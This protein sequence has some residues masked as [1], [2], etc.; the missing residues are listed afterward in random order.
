MWSTGSNIDDNGF[1]WGKWKVSKDTYILTNRWGNF[2]YLLL[3]SEKAMLIDTGYG[4]GNIRKIVESITSLPVTVV[5]THGH[6]D[7]VGGN[8]YWHECYCGRKAK[9]DVVSGAPTE[10]MEYFNANMP[11][12]FIWHEV[13][14]GDTFE[15]GNRS[16]EVFAVRAHAESGIALLDKTNRL[17][18][19]GDEIDPGQVLLD[20][21]L[22]SY[23]AEELFKMHLENVNKL[24]TRKEEYDLLCPAHNG[25]FI[26]KDYL[27]EFRILDEQLLEGTAKI[28]D[29]PMG[30][31]WTGKALVDI[32]GVPYREK[33]AQYGNA[34]IVWRA[35]S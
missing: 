21:N 30:F 15:L 20:Y 32:K 17:L 3:G 24:L 31:N 6:C 7:H 29:S 22:G 4:E 34:S 14:D 18:F 1:L 8:F 10:F 5:N 12:D 16:L 11:E 35:E 27:E 28:A 25:V 33:R 19:T 2:C 13:T 26:S 9:D 23:G